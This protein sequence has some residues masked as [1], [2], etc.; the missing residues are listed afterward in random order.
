MSSSFNTEA[1]IKQHIENVRKHLQTIISLLFVRAWK[2]DA[3]KLEEPELSLWKK[4]DEEPRYQYGTPEYTEKMARWQRVFEYHYAK[5]RHHPEHFEGGISDMN[6]IDIIEMM[7]DW[8][9]YKKVLTYSEACE[10]VETQI[11]RYGISEELGQIIK[12]TL[13]YYFTV[14]GGYDSSQPA[15]YNIPEGQVAELGLFKQNLA[16]ARKAYEPKVDILA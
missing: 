11:K 12:N 5:N 15:E 13:D 6:L 10:V 8:L 16:L 7:C 4:M 3:S 1:F 14:I 9:G 2:H